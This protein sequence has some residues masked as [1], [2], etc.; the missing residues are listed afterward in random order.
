[1]SKIVILYATAGIGHKKAALAIKEAFAEKSQDDVF[2]ADALDYTN[3]FFRFSYSSMYISIVKHLPTVWGFFYYL[4]DNPLVYAAIKPIRRLVN[5]INSAG[6]VKFLLDASPDTVISTHFFSTE[7]VGNLKATGA[8]KSRL[9]TV[10]T[11]YK[12][13]IFWFAKNTDLYVV[14]SEYTKADLMKREIP[15][16]RIKVLG[17]PCSR[18]FSRKHDR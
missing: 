4:L 16:D 14:G 2:I 8:L 18:L 1:M 15:E 6:L 13:H 7:V 10:I 12:S 3:K 11:D 17:I 5:H 9:I